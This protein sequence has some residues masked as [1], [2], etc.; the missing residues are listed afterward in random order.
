[1]ITLAVIAE[2][3]RNVA[4]RFAANKNVALSSSTIAAQQSAKPTSRPALVYGP[5]KGC[6]LTVLS[7]LPQ[8]C[9]FQLNLTSSPVTHVPAPDLPWRCPRARGKLKTLT[10]SCWLCQ[11]K[12]CKLLQNINN[13]YT[14]LFTTFTDSLHI[15]Q[16]LLSPSQY[17]GSLIVSVLV[18]II[19]SI[20]SMVFLYRV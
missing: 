14:Q 19:Q 13:S 4:M 15:T 11:Q 6:C 2:C 10:I 16:S 17:I 3:N 7:L 1:M 8:V 18:I 5:F 20:Q 12:T 9:A